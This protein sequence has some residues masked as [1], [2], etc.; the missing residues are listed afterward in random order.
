MPN[1]E[2]RHE[3]LGLH[4]NVSDTRQGLIRE[5]MDQSELSR[6]QA[7]NTVDLLIK[8]GKLAEVEDEGLGRVLVWGGK[9]K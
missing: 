3:E 5:L 4:A 8:E 6:R 9:P 2:S 1:P 7:E